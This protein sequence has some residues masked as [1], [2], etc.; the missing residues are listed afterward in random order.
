MRLIDADELN[1]GKYKGKKYSD[2]K[3]DIPYLEWLIS[4]DKIS[5]DEFK[6]I[7]K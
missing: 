2:I 5:I 3:D 6:L 1:F 7:T 4:I